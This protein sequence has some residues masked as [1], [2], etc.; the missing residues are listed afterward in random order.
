MIPLLFLF[1]FLFQ[2]APTLTDSLKKEI[3]ATKDPKVKAEMYYQVAKATYASDQDLAIAYADSAITLAEK[4]ILNKV[5]ANSLNIKGVCYLIKSSYDIAMQMHIDALKIRESIQDTVGLIESHLN[6]GNILYR[7]GSAKDAIKRYQKSLD[8]A[9]MANNLR[10]QSLLYNNVGSYYKD[11]WNASNSKEDLDSAKYYL[12][13]SFAIKTSLQDVRGSINTMN[14]LAEIARGS[15]DYETAKNL[16][17]QAL[18]FSKGLQNSEIQISLL[19]ELTDFHLEIKNNEQ[20]LT[21]AKQAMEMANK[22]DSPYQIGS[23]AG[24]VSKVYASLGDYKNAYEYIKLKLNT[25]QELNSEQT[26]NI[27]E[28]LLIK[29]EAEKKEEENKRLLQEQLLLDLKLKRK[30]DLLISAAILFIVLIIGWIFQ[31]RKNDQLAAA[32]LQ[33][34]DILKKLETKNIEIAEKTQELERSNQALTQSNRSRQLLFSVLSHDLKSP[35]SSLQS[36]LELENSKSI[37]HEEFQMILPHVS[38]QIKSVRELMESIL[39]WAHNELN[40]HPMPIMEVK[41]HPLVQD[42]IRQF[43]TKANDKRLHLINDIPEDLVLYTEKDRLNFIIRNLISNAIKYTPSN[44]IIR[45]HYDSKTGDTI[46]ITDS[47][48]GL[49]KDK[50]E[51]LFAG[52]IVSKLGTKGEKGSGI[53][54]LLCKEFAQNIGAILEVSSTVNEGSTFAIQ[55]KK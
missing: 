21:Y 55:W 48:I 26:K 38:E 52:R 23:V 31:K 22:M 30:N 34:T 15:K 36:L 10:A 54:L 17:T 49:E 37:T 46:S 47:G 39:N 24:M 32:H 2:Q 29:Y 35:I 53:G 42:N 25:E 12:E 4:H 18:E 6:I 9:L 41:I 11:L 5:K 3:F 33:T 50:L 8:Y 16:L 43:S 20:A 14:L 28:E 19:N 13:Q 7:T 40:E 44:G 27:R 51:K 45:I 1:L